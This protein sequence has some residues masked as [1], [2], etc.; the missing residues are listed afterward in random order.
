MVIDKIAIRRKAKAIVYS[1]SLLE[2]NNNTNTSKINR[3][4]SSRTSIPRKAKAIVCTQSS[5]ENNTNINHA[6]KTNA[7]NSSTSIHC[8][9][10]VKIAIRCKNEGH[11][12]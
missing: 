11:Y 10:I 3:S 7:S 8:N 5:L 4:N 1:E 9:G 12:S 2:N 6:S